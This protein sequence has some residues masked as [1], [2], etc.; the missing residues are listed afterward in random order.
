MIERSEFD[1][2]RRLGLGGLSTMG[3]STCTLE[4]ITL[5]ALKVRRES[6]RMVGHNKTTDSSFVN[7]IVIS[8]VL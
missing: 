3:A 1:S 5:S 7:L 6:L 4:R 8:P 2:Q